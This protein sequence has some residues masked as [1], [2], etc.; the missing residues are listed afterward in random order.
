MYQQN[1][2]S[3]SRDGVDWTLTSFAPRVSNGQGGSIARKS[4]TEFQRYCGNDEVDVFTPM[5]ELASAAF[6]AKVPFFTT[7]LIRRS[8]VLGRDTSGTYYYVDA[9][10]QEFGGAGYRVFVG[11]KGAMKQRPLLDVASDSAGMVF[12]TKSGEIR[13][14]TSTGSSTPKGMTWFA[15]SKAK[16]LVV[17]DNHVESH[18]IFRDLGLYGFLGTLCDMY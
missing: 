13:L 15:K 10:L 9:L 5:T 16:E 7:P 12:S 3:Q 14:V 1:V 2:Y 17:L 18:L 6:L 11:R 4:A 8:K